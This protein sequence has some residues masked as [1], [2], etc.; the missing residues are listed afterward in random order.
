MAMKQEIDCWTSLSGTDREGE[1]TLQSSNKHDEGNIYIKEEG[2]IEKKMCHSIPRSDGLIYEGQLVTQDGL[3]FTIKQ[4]VDTDM[5]ESLSSTEGQDPSKQEM[6]YATIK[7]EDEEEIFEPITTQGEGGGETEQSIPEDK[8]LDN[9]QEKIQPHVTVC[10]GEK[11]HLCLHCS[12]TCTDEKCGENPDK[13]SH[14]D[15]TTHSRMHS[16]EKPYRCVYCDK[17]FS[18]K[19]KVTIHLKT[20]TGEKPLR[21]SHCDTGFSQ[22]S[23]LKGHLRTHSGKKPSL[24]F[25]C[26][27]GFSQRSTLRGHLRTHSGKKPCRCSHCEW[28]FIC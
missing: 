4:E 2:E 8:E 12:K 10:S 1:G 15:L 22:R 3:V 24:S 21:C 5:Y 27:T 13:C 23:T 7:Q 25:H 28:D 14:C 20:H 16:G 11:S 9:G 18:E 19:S 6:I 17:G 26:D